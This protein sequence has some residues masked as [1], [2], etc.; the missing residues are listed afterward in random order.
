MEEMIQENF[1][2]KC[3]K[4]FQN[5]VW[6]MLLRNCNHVICVG[7]GLEYLRIWIKD[8]HKA[9][10]KCPKNSCG[11]R[12]HENDIRALLD[13][14][15]SDLDPFLCPSKRD[16]LLFHHDQDVIRYALGG[17]NFSQQCPLCLVT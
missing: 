3:V 5:S 11:F 17:D 16:W 4:C 15:N 6:R 12:I 13:K 2:E 9:R 7:C 14:N 8:E 1:S 10:I